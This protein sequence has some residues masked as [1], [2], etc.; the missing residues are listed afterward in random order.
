MYLITCDGEA[1]KNPYIDNCPRCTPM[2]G[3]IPMC[4]CGSK[5]PMKVTP[6][7]YICQDCKKREAR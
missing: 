5:K 6:K 7:Y 3:K 2:W 4:S 1:H